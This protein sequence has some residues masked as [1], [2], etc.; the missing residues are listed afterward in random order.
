MRQYEIWWAD[1]RGPA[2]RRPVLLL[3]R[4]A[5]YDY[6]NKFI[7]AEITTT[8]RNIAQ[9]VRLGR[10]EGMSKACVAN[11]D[12]LRTV[13]KSTLTK[14]AGSLADARHKEVKRAVG[15]ALGWIE[16]LD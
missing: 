6:L 2:R 11:C 9:E 7:V 16:L 4:S 8:I 5:A 1:L 3:S 13:A 14:R 15:Y 10:A 12:N